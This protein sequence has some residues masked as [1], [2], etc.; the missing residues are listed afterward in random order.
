MPRALRPSS[1]ISPSSSTEQFAGRG[2]LSNRDIAFSRGRVI[3]MTLGRDN[4]RSR[5]LR[6]RRDLVST[7]GLRLQGIS[8]VFVIARTRYRL[9][10]WRFKRAVSPAFGVS[11]PVGQGI[12]SESRVSG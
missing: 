4:A 5:E 9:I 6:P 2:S 8:P 11:K 1:T 7:A 12:G 10:Y 3:A